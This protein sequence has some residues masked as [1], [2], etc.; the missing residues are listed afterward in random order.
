MRPV[1]KITS[2]VDI[3]DYVS[4]AAFTSAMNFLAWHNRLQMTAMLEPWKALVIAQVC[5]ARPLDPLEYTTV[6]V[7]CS[8]QLTQCP[9]TLELMRE[10]SARL[11]D[12]LGR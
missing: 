1:S 7:F 10:L 11:E 6:K 5:E 9:R 3:R 4:P 12:S 2:Y 8:E